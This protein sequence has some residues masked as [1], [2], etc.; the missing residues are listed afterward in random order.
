[1]TAACAG[2]DMFAG[3]DPLLILCCTASGCYATSHCTAITQMN[4]MPDSEVHVTLLFFIII[5]R[6]LETGLFGLAVQ[7]TSVKQ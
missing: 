3:C 1:M 7:S 4:E 2:T 5:L 6:T